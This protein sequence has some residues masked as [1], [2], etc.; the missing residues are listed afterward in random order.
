MN[1][2]WNEATYLAARNP[3]PPLA[4]SFRPPGKLGKFRSVVMKSKGFCLQLARERER[5]ERALDWN[6]NRA[7]MNKL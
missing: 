4:S 2:K 5:A 1:T 3:L 7:R 6:V